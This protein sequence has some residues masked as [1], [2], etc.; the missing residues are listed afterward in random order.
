M[1]ALLFP[2]TPKR[3]ANAFDNE[4]RGLQQELADA[5]E[6]VED[7]SVAGCGNNTHTAGIMLTNAVAGPQPHMMMI[8]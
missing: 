1:A 5:H 7:G 3:F 4:L 8:I 6:A 2:G